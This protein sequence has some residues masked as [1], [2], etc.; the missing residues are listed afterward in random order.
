MA[1]HAQLK[2]VMTE[3]SK[4]QIRLA[5]LKS[6]LITVPWHASTLCRSQFGLLLVVNLKTLNPRLLTVLFKLINWSSLFQILGVSGVL[7][8]FYFVS[9]RNS[10]KQTV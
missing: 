8:H 3:C 1:G 6:L 5:G 2:F 7:F 4:T 9:N 10:C